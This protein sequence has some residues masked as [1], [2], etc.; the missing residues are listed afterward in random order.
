MKR[1]S[2]DTLIWNYFC[3]LKYNIIV[4]QNIIFGKIMIQTM[5]HGLYLNLLW[6]KN[7]CKYNLKSSNVA[8]IYFGKTVQ[9]NWSYGL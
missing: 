1:I 8:G 7:V 3:K 6:N 9:K 5:N 2:F 4:L